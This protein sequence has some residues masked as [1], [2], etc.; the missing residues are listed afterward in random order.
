MTNININLDKLVELIKKY[1]VE[2]S[3][4]GFFPYTQKVVNAKKLF[5]EI[6]TIADCDKEIFII[7]VNDLNT[8]VRSPEY[9]S[10]HNFI[11]KH[12]FANIKS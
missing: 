7:Y 11:I 5:E 10:E 4:N 3:F 1:T 9:R 12:I 6:D 2:V 8:N